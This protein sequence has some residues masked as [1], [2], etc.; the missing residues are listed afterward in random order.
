MASRKITR[1]NVVA[2]DTEPMLHTTIRSKMRIR[3]YSRPTNFMTNMP[4]SSVAGP[5]STHGKIAGHR[6]VAAWYV[7]DSKAV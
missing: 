6:Y 2:L 3:R 5:V 4:D 1:K 7:A